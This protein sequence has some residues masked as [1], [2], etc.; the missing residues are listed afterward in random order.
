[1]EIAIKRKGTTSQQRMAQRE[2]LSLY[3][4]VATREGH[5]I[6]D[7]FGVPLSKFD[8]SKLV[9]LMKDMI[10]RSYDEYDSDQWRIDE[11]EDSLRIILDD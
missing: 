7:I 11:A 8:Y 1:M 5:S 2:I 4:E 6:R 3:V 10:V 9:S